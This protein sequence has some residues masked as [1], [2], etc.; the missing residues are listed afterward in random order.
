MHIVTLGLGTIFT[1]HFQAFHAF[2]KGA[3]CAG[4]KIKGHHQISKVI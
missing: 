1:D 2:K 3:Y 4:I